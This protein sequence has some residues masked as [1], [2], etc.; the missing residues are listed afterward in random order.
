[1]SKLLVSECYKYKLITVNSKYNTYNPTLYTS[2]SEILK[3][4]KYLL[5]QQLY[6]C[7][8]QVKKLH[9]QNDNLIDQLK[10]SWKKI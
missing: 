1:M 3:E 9:L 10:K 8:S 5:I 7:N 6:Y 2:N 4:N